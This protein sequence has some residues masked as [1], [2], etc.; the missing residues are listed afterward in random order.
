MLHAVFLTGLAFVFHVDFE[1]LL[2]CFSAVR[3]LR[4]VSDIC[5]TKLSENTEMRMYF[6]API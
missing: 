6:I 5:G 3:H 4:S 2:L 1:T